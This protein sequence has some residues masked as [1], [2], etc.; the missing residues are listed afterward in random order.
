[1]QEASK[2]IDRLRADHDTLFKC[3]Q[4]TVRN[5][6]DWRLDDVERNLQGGILTNNAGN[7]PSELQEMQEALAKPRLYQARTLGVITPGKI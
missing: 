7:L 6:R 3:L 2:A 1:M 5:P 4:V